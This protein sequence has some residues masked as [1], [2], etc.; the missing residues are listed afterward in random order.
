M[1]NSKVRLPKLWEAI[2]IFVII[3]AVLI[4]FNTVIYI[5]T[6]IALFVALVR[7]V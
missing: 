4:V 3:L 5:D 2:V 7:C 1:E 6:P